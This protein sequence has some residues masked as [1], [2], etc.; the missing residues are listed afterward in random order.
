MSLDRLCYELKQ[1]I[2]DGHNNIMQSTRVV[3]EGIDVTKDLLNYLQGNSILEESPFH[4][5]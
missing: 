2:L 4:D 5:K 1:L 3:L